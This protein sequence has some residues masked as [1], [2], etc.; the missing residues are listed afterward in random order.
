MENAGCVC[1]SELS[2]ELW[3]NLILS[4]FI[5]TN[6]MKARSGEIGGFRQET[7]ADHSESVASPQIFL[8]GIM[9]YAQ[10]TWNSYP[11]RVSTTSLRLFMMQVKMGMS[12]LV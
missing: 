4:I 5:I 10:E 11:P 1:A 3:R 6:G 12:R 7:G 2:M 9:I 8:R